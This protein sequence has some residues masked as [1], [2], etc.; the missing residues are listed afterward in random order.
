MSMQNF[1]KRRRARE[2]RYSGTICFLY[3]SKISESVDLERA[4][5]ILVASDVFDF[6]LCSRGALYYR[7][8]RSVACDKLLIDQSLDGRGSSIGGLEKFLARDPTD[9]AKMG[10]WNALHLLNSDSKFSNGASSFPADSVRIQVSPVAIRL[11]GDDAYSLCTPMIR[12][13][14]DG[15]VSVLFELLHRFE[16]RLVAE[17]VSNEVNAATRG[18]KSFQVNVPFYRA[19][20][21]QQFASMPL[22]ARWRQYS[23]FKGL[24]RN[25]QLIQ[26]S[27]EFGDDKLELVE[28]ALTDRLSLSDIARNLISMIERSLDIGK[29]PQ[30]PQRLAKQWKSRNLSGW[31]GKPVLIVSSHDGQLQ[32]AARN[33]A[34]HRL[35]INSVMMRSH[36]SAVVG[37]EQPELPDLRPFDDF[38]HYFSEGVSLVLCAG[39]VSAAIRAEDS[40]VLDNI[41]ADTLVLTEA[42]QFLQVFYSAVS[43]ELDRCTTSA[44]VARLELRLMGLDEAFFNGHRYGETQNFFHSVRSS[45]RTS[46]SRLIVQQKVDVA[47]KALEL[48]EKIAGDH[49]TR[50][51]TLTF[52]VLASATLSPELVQ[53]IATAQGWHLEDESLF[54]VVCLLFSFVIVASLVGLSRS[55]I[56][57][58][59]NRK[60]T[61]IVKQSG[62]GVSR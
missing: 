35:L 3:S 50:W 11:D 53:P 51:I 38:N 12:L 22:A 32:S 58:V 52:G 62:R 2:H 57:F 29:V 14:E 39:K 34:K 49:D 37:M 24:M 21:E 31:F 6:A 9:A 17:I 36:P 30:R 20:L 25:A 45:A 1:L 41:I 48:S 26:E 33:A 8:E 10:V 18:T 23:A 61:R 19:A 7:S 4:C 27:F 15:T 47:R 28:L 40:V 13:Y 54:K 56:R 42:A 43:D 59:S 5:R 16:E 44:D 60:F 46:G 55:I